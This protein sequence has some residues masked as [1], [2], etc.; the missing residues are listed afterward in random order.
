MNKLLDHLLK[1]S[2]RMCK[3]MRAVVEPKSMSTFVSDNLSDQDYMPRSSPHASPLSL[4]SLPPILAPIQGERH[5]R[6]D[7]RHAQLHN[8]STYIHHLQPLTTDYSYHQSLGLGNGAWKGDSG[9]RNNVGTAL[10]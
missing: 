2:A 7:E 5:I 4:T 3:E 6:R 9:M 8:T 1:C 10:V